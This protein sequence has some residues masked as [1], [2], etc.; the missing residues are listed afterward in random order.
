MW[1]INQRTHTQLLPHIIAGPDVQLCILAGFTFFI[2]ACSLSHNDIVRDAFD[3]SMS[4]QSAVARGVRVL[5]YE[6]W[7][8]L[9]D[10]TRAS[11]GMIKRR[12]H[13]KNTSSWRA[14]HG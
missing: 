8:R 3:L 1:R 7:M 13:D 6:L 4:S 12:L 5:L 10:V 9:E 14:C 11:K 2:K